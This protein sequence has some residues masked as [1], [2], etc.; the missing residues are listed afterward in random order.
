MTS[1]RGNG[2]GSVYKTKDGKW[3][4]SIDLGWVDGKRKRRTFQAK[5]Q[6][7][8]LHKMRELQPQKIHGTQLASER[9]S[10]EQYLETWLTKRIPGTVSVRTEE[11]YARVVRLYLVRHL[12]KIRLNKLTPTDVN[13]MMIAL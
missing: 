3:V 13:A 2:E 10:V 5:T 6:A 7:E 11:I 8:A 12:G 4:A 1:R 9:L